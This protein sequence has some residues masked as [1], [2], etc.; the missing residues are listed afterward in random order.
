MQNVFTQLC[1][2][3][4]LSFGHDNAATGP[5]QLLALVALLA[6]PPVSPNAQAYSKLRKH[7]ALFDASGPWPLHWFAPELRS[8]LQDSNNGTDPV[9]A[10]RGE[11]LGTGS[12]RTST[13]MCSGARWYTAATTATAPMISRRAS[14]TIIIWKPQVAAAPPAPA[15]P[16][17]AGRAKQ[18]LPQLQCASTYFIALPRVCP[19]NCIV[20][21][22]VGSIVS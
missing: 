22:S 1:T 2:V 15:I 8:I 9:Q 3:R 7:P 6:V 14:A 5:L 11:R 10:G 4:L 16:Q 20:R 19:R 21:L 13:A 12:S 17:G 18:P